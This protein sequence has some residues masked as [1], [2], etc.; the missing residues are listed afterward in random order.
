MYTSEGTGTRK[1]PSPLLEWCRTDNRAEC[2]APQYPGRA[3]RM[4]EQP[5][6]TAKEMAKQLLPVVASKLYDVPWILVAHSVGTWIAFEFL[7]ACRDVGVPMPRIAFLSGMPSPDIPEDERPWRQQGALGEDEF[8]KECRGWDISEVVFSAAMWPTYQP[9]LRADF[10]L[11]DEY[12]FTHGSDGVFEFPV[13]SFWGVKDR[14]VK[15]HHVK[16]WRQFTRGDFECH[17]ID[18]NHLWP[19]D[20]ASKTA[21]LQHIARKLDEFNRS[22][23]DM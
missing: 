8:K 3:M 23:H 4:K 22:M 7:H 13:C 11:F 16:G 1:T 17:A 21:W 12:V 18:G 10:T 19:L 2:L 15:E 5:I 6:T 14:R 9:L 20:K